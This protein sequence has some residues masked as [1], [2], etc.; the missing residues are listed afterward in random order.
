MSE[1]L[2]AS[3][4]S[5]DVSCSG[6]RGIA[7]LGGMTKR[8]IFR[9][10][11]VIGAIVSS[12]LTILLG[13]LQIGSWVSENAV[14]ILWGTIT[15]LIFAMLL[16]AARLAAV[17]EQANVAERAV[18]DQR[19]RNERAPLEVTGAGGKVPD[20]E[21][22]VQS[23]IGLGKLDQVL[24]EQLFGYASDDE[25]LTSLGNFF[26][27]KIPQG[28]VRMIEELSALP[29]TRAAHDAK[30]A[31]HFEALTDGAQRWLAKFLPLVSARDDYFTTRLD[32]HVSQEAYKQHS[33]STDALGEAGF[34][35]HQKMLE[36]QR[37]F[38]SL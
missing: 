27:Y 19:S 26:P 16:L 14:W 17:Q 22:G 25:M 29:M 8:L 21:A 1:W 10:L 18:R 31:E 34:D 13:V 23:S 12:G 28:P 35:L 6:V 11:A 20:V 15:V 30:L 24:A 5:D 38:A 3:S 33:A 4:D 36:Y 32:Y 9:P 2:L 7:S 37:Y